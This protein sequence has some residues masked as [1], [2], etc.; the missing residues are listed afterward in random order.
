MNRTRGACLIDTVTGVSNAILSVPWLKEL[1]ADELQR[2]N[3]RNAAHQHK[4]N[5]QIKYK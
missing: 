5:M 3:G 1:T 4:K 2:K